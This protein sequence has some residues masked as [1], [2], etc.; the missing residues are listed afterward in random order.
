MTWLE[1]IAW[2]S[3]LNCWWQQLCVLERERRAREPRHEALRIINQIMDFSGRSKKLADWNEYRRLA[4]LCRPHYVRWRLGV[5]TG[6]AAVHRYALPGLAQARPSP[7]CGQL[8]A[9]DTGPWR[10]LS[11]GGVAGGDEQFGAQ[12]SQRSR[13]YVDAGGRRQAH[14][15]HQPALV[16]LVPRGA[17]VHR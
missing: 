5:P 1:L 8:D 7:T 14:P 15:H 17:F 3:V 10:R 4:V 9:G 16:D 11:V 12:D 13:S 6:P 2:N